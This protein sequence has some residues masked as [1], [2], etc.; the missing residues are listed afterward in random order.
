MTEKKVDN[1]GV[2]LKSLRDM[3]EEETESERESAELL[4]LEALSAGSKGIAALLRET[5]IEFTEL[6]EALRKLTDAGLVIQNML[7]EY[8]LTEEGRG[9]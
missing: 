3:E 2:F 9:F 6:R 7:K 8:E 4:V 5:R 1:I